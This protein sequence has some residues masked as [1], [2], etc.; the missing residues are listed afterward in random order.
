MRQILVIGIGAGDPD[1]VTAQ[2]VQALNRA[3][4]FFMVDKGHA[5]D[6]LVHLRK[7]ILDRF[8]T[9]PDYRIVELAEPEAD[10]ERRQGQLDR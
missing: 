1:Y 3:D 4:V 5:K 2:A 7:V 8:V 9:S 6:E 10:E